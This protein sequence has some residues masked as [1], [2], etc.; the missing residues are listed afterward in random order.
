[1]YTMSV[2]NFFAEIKD[3]QGMWREG[4]FS[5]DNNAGMITLSSVN[6]V[7]GGPRIA[8]MAVASYS[9]DEDIRNRRR[10]PAT[11]YPRTARINLNA[12]DGSIVQLEL[13][14]HNR[15]HPGE[16][17]VFDDIT[18]GTMQAMEH[19]NT[20]DLDELKSQIPTLGPNPTLQEEANEHLTSARLLHRVRE[21]AVTKREAENAYVEADKQMGCSDYWRV[22]KWL[23]DNGL[24]VQD[25]YVHDGG[26][27]KKNVRRQRA[28]N[29]TKKR[30][31]RKQ[32]TK[33]RTRRMKPR[34]RK[35]RRKKGRAIKTTLKA[36]SKPSRR[37]KGTRRTAK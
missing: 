21:F 26:K 5:L 37:K 15:S 13:C 9:P 18:S 8:H 6:Y 25:I 4:E 19:A 28:R 3:D 31:A 22:I 35:D 33:K 1:M 16:R 10:F 7:S 24:V 14:P 17:Q 32:S 23:E 27:R 20:V 11:I 2:I 29:A 12:S 36:K 30:G 34:K